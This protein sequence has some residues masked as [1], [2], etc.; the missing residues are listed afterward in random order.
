MEDGVIGAGRNAIDIAKGICFPRSKNEERA[1]DASV[2]APLLR[3]PVCS[4]WILLYVDER[5]A[6]LKA[7]V[8][9]D[10][11][12]HGYARSDNDRGSIHDLLFP[13]HAFLSIGFCLLIGS[14]S[15]R[16]LAMTEHLHLPCPSEQ[17]KVAEGG[18]VSA[19]NPHMKAS[20]HELRAQASDYSSARVVIDIADH[21]R[22]VALV[23][24]DFMGDRMNG[25]ETDGVVVIVVEEW[26]FDE[27]TG[28][29]VGCSPLF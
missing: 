11:L 22:E 6:T 7:S 3:L 25:G 18:I 29:I 27:R 1:I 24:D 13:L 12:A 8:L 19:T 16:S 4:Y 5:I 26:A 20:L 9:D 23:I 2:E 14:A 17:E 10:A 15:V 21:G 28:C